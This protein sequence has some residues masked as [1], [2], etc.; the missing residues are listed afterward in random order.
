MDGCMLFPVQLKASAKRVHWSACMPHFITASTM[1]RKDLL[2]PGGT[3][4]TCVTSY[5][6]VTNLTVG[7]LL[8][9]A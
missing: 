3:S 2:M 6:S 4:Y 5:T 7:D 8:V 9:P 1:Q